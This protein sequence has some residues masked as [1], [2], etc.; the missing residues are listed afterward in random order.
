VVAAVMIGAGAA[1]VGARLFRPHVQPVL[2][3]AT[4]CLLL[5]AAQA[6]V[7]SLMAASPLEAFVTDTMPALM[8]P[9]PVDVA[10]G[11]MLGVSMGLGFARSMVQPEHAAPGEAEAA[12]KTAGSSAAGRA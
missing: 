3:F 2:L 12:S 5:G 9:M 6:A 10:A 4:P 8:M 7:G 1:G 11:T